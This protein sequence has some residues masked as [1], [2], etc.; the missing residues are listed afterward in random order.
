MQR[1]NRPNQT[2][3]PIN[4]L[5]NTVHTLDQVCFTLTGQNLRD[6]TSKVFNNLNK[7]SNITVCN[8]YKILGVLP[9]AP[10]YVVK[11]VYKAVANKVHPDKGGSDIEFRKI[12]EAYETI[13]K[14][15]VWKK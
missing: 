7:Q 13:C 12:Q 8:P 14:Q 3:Q 5:S 10:E 1:K 15:R 11:A 4:E 9:D 6:F 2:N